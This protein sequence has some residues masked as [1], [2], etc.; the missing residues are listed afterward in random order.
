MPLIPEISMLGG[1]HRPS[2]AG[3]A[4]A[5]APGKAAATVATGIGDIG[6]TVLNI[7]GKVQATEDARKRSTLRTQ[8]QR[9]LSELELDLAKDADPEKHLDKLENFIGR[10]RAAITDANPSARAREA[11]ELEFADFE[12]DS[13]RRVGIN[14]A[15]LSRER[16]GLALQNEL[17]TAKQTGNRDAYVKALDTAE[18]GTLVLPERR[19]S[20]L[21]EF[22]YHSEFR[23]LQKE[24]EADPLDMER[25]LEAPDFLERYPNQN[26]ESLDSL[27]RLASAEANRARGEIWDNVLN[28]S[29]DGKVLS[30]DELRQMAVDGIISPQQRA[31]YLDRWHQLAPPEFDAATYNQ[32]FSAVTS[33]EP[34]N[35]PTGATVAQL[36]QNLGTLAL[37]EESIRELKGRLE[38]RLSPIKRP[39]HKLA[40]EFEK[41]TAERF[42]SGDFGGGWWAWQPTVGGDG[43]PI[44]NRWRKEIISREK[45]AA[46]HSAR[47]QFTA[48]WDT[49]LQNSGE[50]LDTVK[51]QQTYDA[52]FD[53]MI[54][55]REDS[56][57]LIPAA[58]PAFDF[59]RDVDSLLGTPAPA[60][61][62]ET[63]ATSSPGTFGG[64]PIQPPGTFYRNA[65]PTVFGGK[66][67]PA[68]NGLSAFGGTTG[69]GGK[70]GVAIPLDVLKATFP[71]KDKAWFAANVR[72]VVKT[73][74][75]RQ[76][77]LPLADLGTAE[78]VW[79]RDKRPVL[80]LTPGAVKA[81]GG[82]VVTKDGKLAGVAGL[83]DLSFALTTDNAGTTADLSA[84]SWEEASSAWF[85][86]KKP[87]DPG[88]IASGLAALRSAW[89]AAQYPDEEAPAPAESAEPWGDGTG[90]SVLP[91]LEGPGVLPPI[92][93]E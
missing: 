86:D 72:A 53:R 30:K 56:G 21:R 48:A 45:W 14:A 35:D 81:L 89:L 26:P 50:D 29:L 49:Y 66:S 59:G 70:E 46:A 36:R 20:L 51:A 57:P 83:G 41:Q 6:E 12:T 93:A 58:P 4:M 10:S 17:E 34:A 31:S 24:I 18:E 68:D 54:L 39:A 87:T 67:D 22:D 64:Q 3:V 76:A 2:V 60:T 1:T 84:M 5:G 16:A 43:Q 28:A 90:G 82:S 77:V 44:P 25:D 85:T 47:Q 33:Y 13:R 19:V 61:G 88:Q 40:S 62:K 92:P 73:K 71:G 78:W 42:D 23:A 15:R 38:A 11:L 79:Q 91:E 80:D 7:A 74:D 52:L 55:D 63:S 32:A 27:R 8:W 65:R 75:G 9:G 69:E 37:P